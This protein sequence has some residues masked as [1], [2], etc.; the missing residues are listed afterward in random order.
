MNFRSLRG[1]L[2]IAV[3]LI[4]LSAGLG[5]AVNAGRPS[6][7]PLIQDWNKTLKERAAERNSAGIV[8]MD[9]D[10][11][12]RTYKNQDAV[13]IDA[14]SHD[15]YSMEHIPGALNLPLE[16]ADDLLPK[17]LADIPP[18]K[19]IITYCDSAT[20]EKGRELAEKL[21]GHGWGRAAVFIGGMMEW[22]D[23]GLP[24]SSGEAVQ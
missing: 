10:E 22:L 15:F 9:L 1:Q 18:Q 20:C 12:S 24:V 2:L 8:M 5:L 11:F 14:R 13:V 3:A 16:K 4:I 17:I 21:V 23:A 19:I 6:G 7:L